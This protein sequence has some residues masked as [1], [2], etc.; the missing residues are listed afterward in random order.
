MKKT[1]FIVFLVTTLF[2]WE[3]NAQLNITA[4]V[5]KKP[6]RLLVGQVSYSYLYKTSANIL[7]YNSL[8]GY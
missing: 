4:A 5:E 7:I 2:C 8:R 1:L 6:E 3:A